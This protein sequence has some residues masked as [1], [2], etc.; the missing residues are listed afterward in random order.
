MAPQLSKFPA[1]G[2]ATGRLGGVSDSVRHTILSAMVPS[3]LGA[4]QK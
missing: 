2:V 3:N 1:V 4:I